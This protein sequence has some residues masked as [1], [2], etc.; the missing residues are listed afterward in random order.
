MRTA[1]LAYDAV[2]LVAAL[3]K[4]QGKD[5]FAESVLTNSSGFTGID[6]SV[7]LPPRRHQ[8]A[9]AGGAA[10]IADRRPD[11]QRA[12][13]G[14][15]RFRDLS[16]LRPDLPALIAISTPALIVDQI[17]LDANIARMA[18]MSHTVRRQASPPCQDPQV[19][20]I[21]GKQ[22][23][24]APVALPVP[25]FRSGSS[26]RGGRD[27]AA[28]HLAHCRR[29][30]DRAPC[31]AAPDAVGG[32]GRSS[33]AKSRR[34]PR[35][36][37]PASRR[38][39]FCRRRHRPGPDRVANGRTAWRWRGR[40][41]SA[42]TRICGLQGYAGHIQHIIDGEERQ[43]AAARSAEQ[44]RAVVAGL[45]AAGL[46]CQVISGSG[47]GAHAFD[48]SGPYTEWQVG[49][50]VFMD[51]DYGRIRQAD[52]ER[53]PFAP[54]L[55]VL[56]TVVSANQPGRIT[57]DAGTKALATNGPPPDCFRGYP[58]DAA[59]PSAATSTAS[60]RYPRP[61]PPPLGTRLIGATHRD[62]T[63]NLHAR[64]HVVDASG[65]VTAVPILGRYGAG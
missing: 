65:A 40:H 16:V 5:R 13:Q 9:R 23:P 17:A 48:A 64:Y 7:P 1:S 45:A 28:D 62:P 39:R 10:R 38:S 21:A 27:R 32:R 33:E 59:T 43:V 4:T 55:F 54:A 2:A 49:S 36:W 19:G 61:H 24:P 41:G 37:H 58:T 60:S 15:R 52:G 18:Q 51:A 29:G 30:Q 47:T 31:S 34:W 56:A 14:L 25:P 57:I 50:Y 53:L 8:P 63:V 6:R 12:A 20:F 46:N 26:C 35:H 42:A 22:P 11:D 3:V 44:L